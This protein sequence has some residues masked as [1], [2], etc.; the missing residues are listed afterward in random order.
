MINLLVEGKILDLPPLN[1][2]YKRV[3]NAFTFGKLTLSRSQS[4]KVPK[5]PNNLNIFNLGNIW[6]FGE[7]ERRY[8]DAQLQ[9]SGFVENGLLY[10]DSIDD[11][12]N[13]VFLFGSLFILKNISNVKKIATALEP[14]DQLLTIPQ[15]GKPANGVLEMYDF[16]NYRNNL[17][18]INSLNVVMPSIDVREI[19]AKANLI[20]GT[21]FDVDNLPNLRIIQQSSENPKKENVVFA[22][23]SLN[24]FS[25]E[26]NLK[27]IVR[28]IGDNNVICT[29]GVR[30]DQKSQSGINYF[31]YTYEDLELSFPNDFPE[32]IFCL[33][34][35]SLIGSDGFVRI[36]V[37]FYGDYS[38]DIG[39]RAVSSLS[40]EGERATIGEPLS[41]RTIVI[42]AQSRFGFYK[43]ND[44]H[45]TTNR[46]GENTYY[47]HYRGFFN[48]DAS[49]F[50]Y[51]LKNVSLKSD[52]WKREQV[53]TS[54]VDNLPEISFVELLNNIA[55]ISGKYVTYDE[56][57]HK[58]R[59]GDYSAINEV[60]SL[61]NVITQD[62]MMREGITNYQHNYVR[63]KEMEIPTND[64]NVV[65]YTTDNEILSIEEDLLTLPFATG[66][67]VNEDIYIDDLRYADSIYSLRNK[68]PLLAK[69]GEGENLEFVKFEKNTLLADIYEK[70]TKIEVTAMMSLFEYMRIKETNVLFYAN[71]NWVWSTSSW[72]KNKAK[73]VL[74]K[75]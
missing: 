43:K 24:V 10:I 44:F 15:N 40:E 62:K 75:I 7:S 14:Y 18:A 58:I 28:T 50:V 13:C 3:N 48:G 20:F 53:Y 57:S 61:D 19:F 68:V 38:F 45:N 39:E 36:D 73:F 42:P 35:S 56:V 41:G 60:V 54:M 21:I 25:S 46:E 64:A 55:I 32:D 71:N 17:T 72:T 5:T 26:Q 23:T 59:L 47:N 67:D 34:N 22:K 37:S 16:A 6:Q 65:D 1:I 69:I 70:S 27:L 31:N 66:N 12:Y 9:G 30:G 74:H 29:T 8:F 63:P 4:F 51:T 11:N 33:D 2:S 49:P 52:Q